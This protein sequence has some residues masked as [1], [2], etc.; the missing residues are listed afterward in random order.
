MSCCAV[1]CCAMLCCAVQVSHHIH[2]NDQT[3]DEDVCRWGEYSP[4]EKQGSKQKPMRCLCLLSTSR[5]WCSCEAVHVIG[6]SPG[7]SYASACSNLLQQ[8]CARCPRAV[9]TNSSVVVLS[10]SLVLQHV[11][12]AQ[13]RVGHSPPPPKPWHK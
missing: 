12:S 7:C 11:P 9:R 1:P 5:L 13:L 4:W 10:F 2:T 3:L 8:Y 6:P